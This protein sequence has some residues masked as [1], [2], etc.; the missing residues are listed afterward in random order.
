MFRGAA[1]AV[2]QGELLRKLSPDLML[3]QEVNLSAVEAFR[4]AARADWLIC[5]ADL[6]IR[7]ADD[8]PVRSRG[9]AIGGRGP[10]P[11]R[12]W[13][14]AD[15]PVPER[16]LLAEVTVD[17]TGLTAVS[18][19]APPGVNW[20]IAKARQAVAV[21]RWLAAQPGPV[22][23]GADANTPLVD[24]VNFA[25]TR[26]HWH[27]GNRCLNGEPGDDLMFGPARSTCWRTG[28]AAGWL[29]IP[30]RPSR[31]Q[32]A[33]PARW[34]SRTVRAAGGTRPAPGAALTPSG[35]PATGPSVISST[36]TTRASQPAA[37]T[38]LS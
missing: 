13:L 2:S 24:A 18:Y 17:G 16:T 26:T 23:V 14:P 37:T 33:R 29:I 6:R 32:P 19:H 21:A 35:S 28:C 38:Q 20:G 3:L 22:L 31:W 15:V 7:A 25:G 5:A 8:R 10:A 9:V 34:P 11:R 36:F 30:L 4:Q 12:T 1:R 27:T